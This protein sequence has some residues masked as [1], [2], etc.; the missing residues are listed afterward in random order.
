M[1]R[2]IELQMLQRLYGENYKAL[3]AWLDGNINFQLSRAKTFLGF[4][5]VSVNLSIKSP[6]FRRCQRWTFCCDLYCGWWLMVDGWW[7]VAEDIS[8][9][10]AMVTWSVSTYFFVL[11]RC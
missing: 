1:R 2:L 7:G 11:Y 10:C 8:G 9:W 3:E 4:L 5:S 6:R